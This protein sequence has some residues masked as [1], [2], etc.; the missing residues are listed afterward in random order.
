MN[1]LPVCALAYPQL[2]LPSSQRISVPSHRICL[3]TDMYHSFLEQTARQTRVPSFR[4]FATSTS[5]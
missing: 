3:T 4:M 5:K 2:E 1:I